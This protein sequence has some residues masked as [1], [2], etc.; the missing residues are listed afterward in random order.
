MEQTRSW[1]QCRRVWHV[2]IQPNNQIQTCWLN[3][4]RTVVKQ[5]NKHS[6]N[7]EASLWGKISG[8]KVEQ[9]TASPAKL[10]EL[11]L[12]F[13]RRK[14]TV[15]K[16]VQVFCIEV[17]C[18]AVLDCRLCSGSLLACMETVEKSMREWTWSRT[19]FCHVCHLP[20]HLNRQMNKSRSTERSLNGLQKT[21][22]HHW[23]QKRT[24]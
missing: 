6:D 14:W 4:L 12:T 22:C 10:V 21:S 7:R 2:P 20:I 9:I 8:K 23:T 15:V 5:T 18:I 16:Q 24:T 1:I 3:V 17:F 13:A 11:F 19:Q